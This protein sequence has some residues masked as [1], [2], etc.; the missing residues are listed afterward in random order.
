MAAIVQLLRYQIDPRWFVLVALTLFTSSITVKVPSVAATLSVSEAFVFSSVILF[1]WPAGT[2]LASLD[3]LVISLWLQKRKRQ[4]FYRVAF[5]AT[6]PAL[7]TYIAA[8][9]YAALG[10]PSVLAPNFEITDIL[11]PLCAFAIT[12]FIANTALL[13]LAIALEQRLSAVQVW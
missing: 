6:A 1:G 3:G 4:P 10:A 2:V 12:Y 8:G 13:S 5:N 11:V 9:V 7:S